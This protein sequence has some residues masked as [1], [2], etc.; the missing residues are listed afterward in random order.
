MCKCNFQKCKW[1]SLILAPP[2][3]ILDGTCLLKH[4]CVFPWNFRQYLKNLDQIILRVN[5]YYFTSLSPSQF[6]IPFLLFLPPTGCFPPPDF[7]FPGASS[8][9]RIK[10]IFSWPGWPLLY[11]CQ[12]PWTGLCMLLV[13]DSFVLLSSFCVAHMGI[14]L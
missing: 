2:Q 14:F 3:R 12:G 11:L 8:L 10:C 7:P 6:L 5:F 4:C 1:G 13:S 9:R